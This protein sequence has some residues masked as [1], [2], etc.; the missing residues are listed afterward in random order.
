MAKGLPAFCS[1]IDSIRISGALN[2][3]EVISYNEAAGRF[4]FQVVKDYRWG[5][6]VWSTRVETCTA[7][8]Q[9]SHRFSR[10]SNGMK[11]TQPVAE[12]FSHARGS[13]YGSPTP[14][15]RNPGA[16]DGAI[17]RANMLSVYQRCG[18]RVRGDP[19]RAAACRRAIVIAALH[20]ALVASAR[21]MPRH[22]LRTAAAAALSDASHVRWPAGRRYL[23]R[24][25]N[26]NA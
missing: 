17:H 1:R 20:T 6:R 9:N 2:L 10:D 15:Y 24:I 16:I 11:P 8:H 23:I 13:F 26:R 4:E 21:S 12:L 18:G 7:C 5:R 3:I 22:R 19:I 14:G 25:S